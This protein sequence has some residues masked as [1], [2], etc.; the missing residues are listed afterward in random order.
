M[1]RSPDAYGSISSTYC[2]REASSPGSGFGVM[3]ASESS[4]TFCHLAS[5]PAGSYRCMLGALSK[6]ASEMETPPRGEALRILRR[7]VPRRRETRS[8]KKECAF[9]HRHSSLSAACGTL[10]AAL[11]RGGEPEARV[12]AVRVLGVQDPAQLRVGA[13]L[14]GLAHE[15]DAEPATP[16]LRQHVDV[17]QPRI[18]GVVRGHAAEA[19]LAVA[20]VEADE[21]RCVVDQVLHRRERASERPVRVLADV[22]VHG[23]DVDPVAVVV[24]LDP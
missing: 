22:A 3:K 10:H 23:R 14:H 6:T 9:A 16:V 15:L 21:A 4:Q 11:G 17:E 18:G 13:V 5:T 2:K 8:E 12:Q 7:H 20:V 1:C 24:E 19:D